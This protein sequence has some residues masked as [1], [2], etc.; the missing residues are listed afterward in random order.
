[1]SLCGFSSDA[2]RQRDDFLYRPNMLANAR[3]HRQGHA[4]RMMH[5]RRD[6]KTCLT[7]S[8]SRFSCWELSMT[9]L[10]WWIGWRAL[11]PLLFF[12]PF[13]SC[14]GQDSSKAFACGSIC[15][16]GAGTDVWASRDTLPL[17][18]T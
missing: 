18:L 17:A 1:M 16:A 11:L 5:A 4:E 2:G 8:A 13:S 7:G 3:F 6:P 15:Q 14:I 10:L 12:V 9:V